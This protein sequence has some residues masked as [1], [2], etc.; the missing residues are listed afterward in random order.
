MAAHCAGDCEYLTLSDWAAREIKQR[1]D[2]ID[3]LEAENAALKEAGGYVLGWHP[4]DPDHPAFYN[5]VA[6]GQMKL[7]QLLEE[8][9]GAALGDTGQDD[10]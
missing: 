10:G 2:R 9:E 3:K 4:T 8:G 7:R 6:Y 5:T 1:D